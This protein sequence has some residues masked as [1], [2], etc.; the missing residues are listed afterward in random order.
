MTP[1]GDDIGPAKV[2][3]IRTPRVGLDAIVV[4]YHGGTEAQAIATIEERIR[5]NTVETLERAHAEGITPRE[6]ATAMA[7]VRVTAA[8]RYRRA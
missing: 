4:E 7:R 1:V 5:A 6:A 3:L 2:V 8:A